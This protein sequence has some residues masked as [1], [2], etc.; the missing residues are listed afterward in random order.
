[1][2]Q[3]KEEMKIPDWIKTVIALSGIICYAFFMGKMTEKL[4]T[5]STDVKDI[6]VELKAIQVCR[7]RVN[8]TLS[9]CKQP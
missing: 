9:I 4:D 2:T 7:K 1:M 3:Q 5:V 6:R 8:D